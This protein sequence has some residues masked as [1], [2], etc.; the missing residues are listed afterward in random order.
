[1]FAAPFALALGLHAGVA[2]AAGN[3]ER[4]ATHLEVAKAGETETRVV[5]SFGAPP[6]FSAR[7]DKAKSR[8]L[9]DLPMADAEGVPNALTDRVGIVGGVMVQSFAVGGGHTTRLLVTLLEEAEYAVSVEGNDLVIRVA[10][11]RTGLAAK[12]PLAKPSPNRPS[13]GPRTRA[14]RALRAFE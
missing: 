12:A 4:K 8:L 3:A 9:V 1:M 6:T 13:Q 7:L 14:G 10:P 5:L 2:F 11:K